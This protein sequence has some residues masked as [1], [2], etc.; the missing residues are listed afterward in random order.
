L[1][2]RGDAGSWQLAT[3]RDDD[4]IRAIWGSGPSEVYAVG[5]DNIGVRIW[6]GTRWRKETTPA[7]RL[8]GVWGDGRGRVWVCGDRVY[9]RTAVGWLPVQ[10][11]EAR[12]FMALWGHDSVYAVG[13]RGG[14]L[15]RGVDGVWRPQQVP[16]DDL[17]VSVWG[18]GPDAIW[19]SSTGGG[20]FR[21]SGGSWREEHRVKAILGGLWGTPGA[22]MWAVGS[23]GRLLHT[24]GDGRWFEEPSG[25]DKQLTGVWGRNA[26]E[27]YAFGLQSSLLVRRKDG[28]Q[29]ISSNFSDQFTAMWGSPQGRD[30]FLA[31]ERFYSE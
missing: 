3:D 2:H 20:L 29:P 18:L 31:G 24:M 5:W 14:V 7:R 16:T 10:G 9:E 1:W 25:T 12:G 6:D 30:L 27:I 22:G 19:A 21:F 4:P 28:W 17:L 23:G 26:S 8:T 15:C 11:A 13:A